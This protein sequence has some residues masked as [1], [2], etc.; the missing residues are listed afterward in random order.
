MP[1]RR[2]HF[3]LF[4]I[5]RSSLAR[6]CHAVQS[7]VRRRIVAFIRWPSRFDSWWRQF[8]NRAVSRP[9][10]RESPLF[11]GKYSPRLNLALFS[12]S[13]ATAAPLPAQTGKPVFY[14]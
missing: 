7:L 12:R 3:S 2:F 1:S 14:S 6:R 4:T 9:P 10:D 13:A 8:A 11:T 5:H